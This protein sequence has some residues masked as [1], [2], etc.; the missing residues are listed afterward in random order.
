MAILGIHRSP[1]SGRIVAPTEIAANAFGMLQGIGGALAGLV[2]SKRLSK[3]PSDTIPL[4]GIVIPVGLSIL[5]TV[6]AS[7]LVPRGAL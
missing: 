5:G 6:A 2:A 7:F 3:V 4:S 1:S